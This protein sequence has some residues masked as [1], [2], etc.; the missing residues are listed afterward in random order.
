MSRQDQSK[1]NR[2]LIRMLNELVE[3]MLVSEVKVDFKTRCL[4]NMGKPMLTPL[5]Q[6]LDENPALVNSLKARIRQALDDDDA[7]LKSREGAPG[8]VIH[9][10]DEKQ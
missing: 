7:W 4:I 8:A 3:Q 9:K 10:E 1:L 2:P 6:K 5:L